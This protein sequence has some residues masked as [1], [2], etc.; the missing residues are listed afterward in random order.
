MANGARLET[1]LQQKRQAIGVVWLAVGVVIVASAA[2]AV[3]LFF[4]RFAVS[5]LAV[6]FFLMNFLGGYM[7][8]L[9]MESIWGANGIIRYR[10]IGIVAGFALAAI[11]I[12]FAVFDFRPSL[13]ERVGFGYMGV[14]IL[15]ITG[16]NWIALRRMQ[17]GE[18]AATHPARN[19]D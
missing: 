6:G 17:A 11:V 5:L 7:V 8:R 2:A 13:G 15:F 3:I 9:G 12:G 18:S 16:W 1:H 14:F 10:K 19:H 4:E